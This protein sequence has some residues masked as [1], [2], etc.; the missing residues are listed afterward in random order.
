MMR[1]T[2]RAAAALV[3]V[4]TSQ[5]AFIALL[6]YGFGGN[7]LNL[8]GPVHAPED[9]PIDENPLLVIHDSDGITSVPHSNSFS[10]AQG[11]DEGLLNPASVEKVAHSSADNVSA[12]TDL[13]GAVLT[14]LEFDDARDWKANQAEVSVWNLTRLYAV[15]GTFDD[16]FPGVNVNPN[17]SVPYHPY[18]W[19]ATSNDTNTEADLQTQI[20]SY[21][22]TDRKYLLAENQGRKFHPVQPKYEHI[23]GTE[24][25]WNQTIDNSPAVTQFKLSFDFLYAIGPLTNPGGDPLSGNCSAIAYVDGSAVWNSSLLVLDSRNAWYHTGEILVTLP[26]TKS[27]FNLEI[28][29]RIDE[30]MYM[31]AELDYDSDGAEDGILNTAYISVRFDDILFVGVSPPGF[32]EVDLQF[33]AGGDSVPV[34]GAAGSGAASVVNSSYWTTSPVAVELT[35]NT[36]VYFDYRASLISHRFENSTWDTEHTRE[37]VSYSVEL[38]G[39]PQLALYA[40]VTSVAGYDNFSLRLSYPDDWTNA[41]VLDPYFID[42]TSQCSIGPGLVEIPYSLVTR[43]GWWKLTLEAPNYAESITPQKFDS[44]WVNDTLY[45]SGDRT[46]ALI[47]IGTEGNTPSVLDLVNTSWYLPNGTVWSDDTVSG[48]VDGVITSS[49]YGL[50]ALNTSAGE[51]SVEVLWTNGTEIAFDIA[52]FEV[53]HAAKLTALETHI[54]TESGSTVMNFVFYQDAENNESLMDPSATILANWSVSTKE[55]HPNNIHLYW[56][57]AT[58]FDTLLVG[59]GNSSVI[60]QAS[61]EFFDNASCSFIIEVTYTDNDLIIYDLAVDVGLFDTYVCEFYFE[62]RYGNYLEGATSD[63]TVSGPVG[64]VNW[65]SFT[66]LGFGNYSISFTTLLSGT[67]QVTITAEAD[68]YES[69]EAT[70]LLYVGEISTGLEIL[71]GTAGLVPYGENYSLVVRYTNSTNHGIENADIT[72]ASVT[73][74]GVNASASIDEGEGFYSLVLIPTEADDFTILVRANITNYQTQVERFTLSVAPIPTN[75]HTVSGNLSASVVFETVYEIEV[76][77]ATTPEDVDIDLASIQVEFTS[78]DLSRSSLRQ[79]RN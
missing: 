44:G 23:S 29:L 75:L 10:F 79:L 27:R 67:Y 2:G 46:R 36:S 47:E 7:G 69:A 8:L 18:N 52:V 41:T 74:D 56:E 37:G 5:I 21:Y 16:G 58:P 49:S 31:D 70:L 59:P 68:F 57:P 13:P 51:W 35:S 42:V 20:A 78:V 39:N 77:Y 55:F 40:F 3:L 66:D 30:Y 28:G 15:N 14:N 45:R 53:H 76:R 1:I 34:T 33:K 71:N 26:T 32:D 50:G 43:L 62:D 61:R 11:F 6:P 72:I 19:D 12:R 73:P 64:G 48:G 63:V 9:T 65:S 38:G 60:V 17:G 22:A 54:V 4:L 24:I 25:L